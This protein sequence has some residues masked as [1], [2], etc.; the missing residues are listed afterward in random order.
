MMC[1]LGDLGNFQM[2]ATNHIG[3]D[4]FIVLACHGALRD[5]VSAE[6]MPLI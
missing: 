3:A 5:Y 6:R 4:A 2:E 1:A